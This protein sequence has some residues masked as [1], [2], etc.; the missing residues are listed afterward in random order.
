VAVSVDQA[1]GEGVSLG[2]RVGELVGE[3][4]QVLEAVKDGTAVH[5][6]KAVSDGR[7]ET[8]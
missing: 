8:V 2:V 7:M 3:G 5:V 1:V 4:A 6:G